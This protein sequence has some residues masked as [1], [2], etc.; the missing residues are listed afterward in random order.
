MTTPALLGEPTNPVPS[1]IADKGHIPNPTAEK[2]PADKEPLK[3]HRER[4][5]EGE[6]LSPGQWWVVEE[7]GLG[8]WR[9]MATWAQAQNRPAEEASQEKE[10]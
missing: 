7:K 10:L 1:G 4:N 6:S 8:K 3:F 2:L 5:Q 9:G